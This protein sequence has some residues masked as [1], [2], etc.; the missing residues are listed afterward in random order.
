MS[1]LL[2]DQEIELPMTGGVGLKECA[3]ATRTHHHKCS[4]KFFYTSSAPPKCV[5][6]AKESDCER[7]RTGPDS[8]QYSIIKGII[9]IYCQFKYRHL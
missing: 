7:V 9:P 6:E 1:C 8:K 2:P 3:E 4:T 5:C